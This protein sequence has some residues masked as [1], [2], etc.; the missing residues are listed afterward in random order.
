[1]KTVLVGDGPRATEVLGAL[2]RH[3]R[4]VL[5]ARV[6]R[7]RTQA[8][9]PVHPTL[10]SALGAG[11]VE[12][13]VLAGEFDLAAIMSAIQGARTVLLMDAPSLSDGSLSVLQHAASS[14]EA[15][16]FLARDPGYAGGGMA[17]RR[18]LDSGRLGPLGHV[19]CED[20]RSGPPGADGGEGHW[21]HRGGALL[22]QVCG[23]LGTEAQDVM[24]RIDDQRGVTEAYVA[25]RRGIHVHYTG[26]WRAAVDSHCLWIEGTKGSLKCD[27]RAIW[28]RKRGWRFF[29]PVGAGGV[30]GAATPQAAVERVMA[31]VGKP[32]ATDDRAV[33]GI[34]AAA[35]ASAASREP[36]SAVEDMSSRASSADRERTR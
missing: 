32:S 10:E 31:E 15:R 35:L 17:L 18:F 27:G 7:D 13:V 24:A 19:S 9:L 20:R 8:V 28:W 34:F 16:I 33:L 11:P 12:L 2:N 25:T 36:A 30:S 5:T 1:M 14:G 6:S 3:P 21:L 26:C 23:C 22:A 4:L 29:I